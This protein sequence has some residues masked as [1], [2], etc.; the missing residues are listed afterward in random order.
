ME[1]ACYRFCVSSPSVQLLDTTLRDG[2]YEVNLQFSASDTAV[3]ASGLAEAGLKYIEV[4][5]GMCVGSHLF[6]P[7]G[8]TVPPSAESDETY[9]RTARRVAKNAEI[10][11]LF[12]SPERFSGPDYLEDLARWGISFVRLAL[13]PRD[14]GPS[15]FRCIERAKGLGLTV[16]INLMQTYIWTPSELAKGSAE[17]AR[18]GADWFYIVD[19]AGGMQ[20][21]EV[22]EYVRAMRGSS[23]IIVGLHAHANSG[24][25]IANCLAA[26]DAGA[27]MVDGTLN[28][29]G[30]ATGN[31][32]TELL[33]LALKARGHETD[34]D[35]DKVLMLGAL[36]RKMYA[37]KGNDP[38]HF[39]SGASLLHSRNLKDVTKAAADKGR[40]LGAFML[41]V[42]KEA[43]AKGRLA[44][45]T[46]P[47][48]IFEAAAGRTR[49]LAALQPSPELVEV[50]AE[51]LESEMRAALPERTRSPVARAK[52]L[53]KTSVLHLA[54]STSAPW[55]GTLPWEAAG[56]I[57]ASI[58]VDPSARPA[59]LP[60]DEKPDVL[61]VD[62]SLEAKALS[63]RKLTLE[64]DMANLAAEAIADLVVASG[65]QRIV[66]LAP[67]VPE[68]TREAIVGRL[69]MLGISAAV[70][71]L[72]PRTPR[73]VISAPHARAAWLEVLEKGDRVILAASGAD[74]RAFVDRARA[75]GAS[76]MLP[77]FGATV[78]ARV[79]SILAAKERLDA[80]GGGSALSEGTRC[81]D[82]TTAPGAGEI[83]VDDPSSPSA[84]IDAPGGLD[85][86]ALRAIARA[87]AL[88][89]LSGRGSL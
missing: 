7:E 51:S 77:A 65:S 59:P 43:R 69:S 60:E 38:I 79:Q 52:K 27:R 40:A 19:S 42:G 64:L 35:L 62:R 66:W 68:Q 12:L 50:L 32:A 5:H 11:V 10:G 39:T 20:G 83:V 8:G 3:I 63:A 80:S 81:V 53:G 1:A 88:A 37:E 56:F 70:D 28:G 61:V 57:G 25:A 44:D 46:F 78:A 22:A 15:L 24:L 55:I 17:A 21:P 36:A 84:I 14:W 85:R 6:K 13:W 45:F 34:I 54:P 72:P 33:L 49:P 26:I 71:D 73:T 30:R 86:A 74:V 47:P 67:N 48:E 75:R 76:V 29:I 4:A 41:E 23:D 18:Y 87:R 31:A 82:P 9:V 2:S 89:L 16:S 58:A